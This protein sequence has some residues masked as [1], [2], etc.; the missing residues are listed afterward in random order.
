MEALKEEVTS[1][2]RND[3]LENSMGL[4]LGRY[5]KVREYAMH[6]GQ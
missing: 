3:A 4:D 6:P 2:I 1:A 5:N